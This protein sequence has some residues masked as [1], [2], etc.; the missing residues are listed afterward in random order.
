MDSNTIVVDIEH[1]IEHDIDNIIAETTQDMDDMHLSTSSTHSL[2]DENQPLEIDAESTQ[3]FNMSLQQYLSID[4]EKSIL[5]DTLKKKNSQKKNYEQTM[6]TYLTNYNI[7]NVTLDGTYKN[8]VIETETKNVPTGFNR[9]T[10]IEV[11][12][13]CL[14]SDSELFDTIM[15]KLSERMSV[16]EVTKLKLLD[17]S[18]KRILKKDKVANNNQIVESILE[19]TESVIPENMRYLYNTTSDK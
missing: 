12:E 2:L 5:Q 3:V 16:K 7:K 15:C 10:V 8:H 9:S 19:N 18:K 17:L 1:D 11:L 4:D 13:E 14:G 6:I